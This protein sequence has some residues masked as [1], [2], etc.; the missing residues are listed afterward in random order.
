MRH[1]N[2]NRT[3]NRSKN[4]RA[5]LIK[6]LT[7]SLITRERI[8]TTEAKAKE[9][10]PKIEKMITRAKNPTL[11]NKRL[12]LAGL[13]NNDAAV[14]KLVE[15]IAPRYSERAGGYTRIIKLMPRKGDASKMAVIELV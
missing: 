5:A 11:A 10:R 1:H 3:F 6:G 13:Y 7:T 9:L 14:K 12:L 15:T 2:A 4:Q 8:Q